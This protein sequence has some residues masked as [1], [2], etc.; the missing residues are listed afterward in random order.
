MLIDEI[1]DIETEELLNFKFYNNNFYYGRLLERIL[2]KECALSWF[3][4]G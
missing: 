1:L 4:K 3:K 2:L